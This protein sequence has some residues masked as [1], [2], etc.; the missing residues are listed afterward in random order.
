[1]WW[2]KFVLPICVLVLASCTASGGVNVNIISNEYENDYSEVRTQLL[3]LGI[4]NAPDFAEALNMQFASELN[5][6]VDGFD[7]D[8]AE[9]SEGTRNGEKSVFETTQEVKYNRNDFLSVTEEQYVYTGGAHGM[10]LRKTRNI[11]TLAQ[12][13]IELGD[14]F[15]EEGYK[16]TLNRMIRDLRTENPDEY[17]ELWEEPT[18]KTGQDFYLTEDDLVIYYQPYELSYYARGFIEFPLRLSELKGYMK[19]E[20]Y[21]LINE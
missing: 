12:K 2:K 15:S 3:E 4:P 7:K 13:E 1:M 11:D 9:V 14:L 17:G 8:A 19:E 18:I 6:S 5:E 20:Y 10:T 16:E 21:R